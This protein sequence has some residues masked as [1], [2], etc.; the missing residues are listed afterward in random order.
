MTDINDDKTTVCDMDDEICALASDFAL[1]LNLLDDYDHKKLDVGG[2]TMKKAAVIPESEFLKV[3]DR[4][5]P[6]F[7]SD[8]FANPKDGSFSGSVNQI[9]QTFDGKDLYPSLEEKAT[10]LLYSIVKNHSFS[11]GNKR[12][13]A[14][15][16]LYFLDK[17]DM[18]YDDCGQTI[19][20]N[21]TLFTLTVLIA[22]S[23]PENME[24]VR[25]I[26]MSILNR[27]GF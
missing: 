19:I 22:E 6:Q 12:I 13:G 24:T 5:K 18:L 21:A 7:G 14:V 27:S 8:V 20:N 23:K 4:M 1:G 11:D 3:I 17:N 25:Q 10:M 9:Y 2:K 15:C 16:F 26:V